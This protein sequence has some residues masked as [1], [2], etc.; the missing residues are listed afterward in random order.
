MDLITL[1][2]ILEEAHT[3]FPKLDGKIR[4]ISEGSKSLQLRLN[5]RH[6][7]RESEPDMCGN[8]DDDGLYYDVLNYSEDQVKTLIAEYRTYRNFGLSEYHLQYYGV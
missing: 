6:D 5:P 2:K 7:I 8:Y 3:T 4:V 1:S